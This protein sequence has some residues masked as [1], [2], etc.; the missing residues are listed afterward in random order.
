MIVRRW[1]ARATAEGADRYRAH[2]A[3]VVVEQ[4]KELDGFRG[5][6]VLRAVD[7]GT[8]RVELIDLTYWE[9][10][11]AITAFAGA[12]VRMAIV[13][14][15]ARQYLLEFDSTVSHYSLEVDTVTGSAQT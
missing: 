9:S 2:F 7:A 10:L 8:D 13:D 11:D 4:L 5:A 6:Q 1:E 12:D 3:T 15:T 14:E